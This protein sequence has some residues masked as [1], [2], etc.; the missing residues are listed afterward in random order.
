MD[1]LLDPRRALLSAAPP[2]PT[3]P[4]RRWGGGGDD[5]DE[6]SAKA[7][8]FWKFASRLSW[9]HPLSS[10]AGASRRS[11]LCPRTV[12]SLLPHSDA[13]LFDKVTDL[14][15]CNPFER[16][17]RSG[18]G[19]LPDWGPNHVACP[20]LLSRIVSPLCHFP[21][22]HVLLCV[23]PEG[24]PCLPRGRVSSAGQR[25]APHF[26]DQCADP[27]GVRRCI[28]AA[29]VYRYGYLTEGPHNTDHAWEE[30]V[31]ARAVF[32]DASMVTER[33]CAGG[34]SDALYWCLLTSEVVEL[35]PTHDRRSLSVAVGGRG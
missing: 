12:G 35:L 31:I 18:R 2:S 10:A 32:A 5:D 23:G 9:G 27:H 26:Y 17:G 8:T 33:L 3:E 6:W 13:I 11:L 14:T 21:R 7:P 30:I 29:P 28:D 25:L 1:P 22:M 19:S 16:T 34:E 15:C 24:R 20:I 4:T